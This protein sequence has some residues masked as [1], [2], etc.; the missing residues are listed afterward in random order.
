MKSQL[1]SA[2]LA[3]LGS[4]VLDSHATEGLER[5][6][7]RETVAP[8]QVQAGQISNLAALSPDVFLRLLVARNLDVQFSKLNTDVNRYLR[9]GE[10]ALYEPVFFLGIRKEGRNRQRTPD[11]RLQSTYA[12]GTAVLDEKVRNDELGIRSKLPTGAEVSVS[13][14][15]SGKANNLIP[16]TSQINASAPDTEYT[17]LLNVTLKQPLFRNAGRA[18]TETD[19]RVAELEHQVSLQQLTQQTLKTSIEGLN[20][21][22]QLY[23]AQETVKLRKSAVTT[24]E[25]L[26]ADANAR[27]SAGKVPPSA[28]LELQSVVLN[29]EAE[30]ARSQQ[31]F[32]EAQTKLTTAINIVWNNDTPVGISPQLRENEPVMALAAPPID[33]VLRLWSPYQIAL[34]R[35]QQAQARLD[36]AQNQVLPSVDFVM[37]YSGTGFSNK[38]QDAR[39]FATGNT[40][41]DWYVGLNVEIP[42]GGNQKAQQQLFAQTT[43]LT[44][45]EVELQAIQ[46]SFANDVVVRLGDLQNSSDVLELS[47][48]ETKLRQ[49]IFDNERQ[50]VQIGSGSFTNLLQKQADFIESNQRMLENQ[51]RYE[52]AVTMWQYTRGSLLVDNGIN[53]DNAS[54]SAH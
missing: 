48:K 28:I 30:L 51:V 18:I 38:H 20:L 46:N 17:S 42:L 11:E 9:E 52:V 39:K 3:L 6:V 8:N 19:R 54:T 12:L 50:R 22:W 41:P 7:Q 10:A 33:E 25:S 36:F 5:Q 24:S 34:L 49:K 16:Q 13:Y 26:M 15:A 37:S 53:I 43:R 40:Y 1:Q 44:Q 2:I 29:R 32:R 45:A 4:I 14:K 23:R 47:K 21:Y 27:I 35:H 31:A